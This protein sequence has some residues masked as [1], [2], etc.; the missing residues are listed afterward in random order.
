MAAGS[1]A[2]ASQGMG[3][4]M[5][6]VN[7]IVKSSAKKISAKRN[8]I[9]LSAACFGLLVFSG[10]ALGNPTTTDTARNRAEP[11]RAVAPRHAR[12]AQDN[13]RLKSTPAVGMKRPMFGW[14]KLVTEARKYVGTNPTARKRL[15]CATFMNMVLARTGY[16]GTGS[17]AA[18]SFA[19]YGKRVNDPQVGAIAVLTRGKSNGHVGIVTGIDANGNPI[20]ISGNHG[21]RVGEATYPRNRVIAYVMPTERTGGTQ[22][23]SAGPS[24]PQRASDADQDG[25]IPSPIEEL[26]AA[27]N[28]ERGNEQ[29][30]Q[31]AREP[32]RQNERAVAQRPVERAQERVAVRPAAAAY[33][34]VQQTADIELPRPRAEA[35]YRVSAVVPGTPLPRERA[36][37][38]SAPMPRS[39][40]Q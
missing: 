22:L 26:L 9:V 20:I 1:E 15:W 32:A 21:K 38:P 34:V 24:L 7:V 18:R 6:A 39:R 28:A 30:P 19:S 4:A 23:A 40:P 14:P 29:R 11:S 16:A 10:V 8:A 12:P 25:G 5:R 17:D 13:T 27:I 37:L 31:A 3:S 33:R 2:G 35:I 36:A